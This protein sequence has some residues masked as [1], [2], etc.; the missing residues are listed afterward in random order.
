MWDTVELHFDYQSGPISALYCHHFDMYLGVF[1]L[2]HEGSG[3][4]ETPMLWKAHA[5]MQKRGDKM[6]SEDTEGGWTSAEAKVRGEGLGHEWPA[7]PDR[8]KD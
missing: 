8:I 6:A 2:V 7:T 1:E 5:Y 3:H 4:S